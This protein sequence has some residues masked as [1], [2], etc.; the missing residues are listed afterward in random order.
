MNQKRS[1]RLISL[2][3]EELPQVHDYVSESLINERVTAD[4]IGVV[5]SRMTEIPIRNLFQVKETD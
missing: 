4:D 2:W 1:D 3:R 5:V